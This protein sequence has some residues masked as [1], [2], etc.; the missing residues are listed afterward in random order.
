VIPEHISIRLYKRVLD[1]YE[2]HGDGWMR[3]LTLGTT[4]GLA[5][6][7]KSDR[8]IEIKLPQRQSG[9]HLLLANAS[10]LTGPDRNAVEIRQLWTVVH[11]LQKVHPNQIKEPPGL[12]WPY[13]GVASWQRND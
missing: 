3:F 11:N 8:N 4:K 10:R 13:G 9:M 7:E 2:R 12:L 1:L 6:A 5:C